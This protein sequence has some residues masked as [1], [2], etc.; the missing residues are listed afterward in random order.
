M[1]DLDHFKKVNDQ[2]GHHIGDQVLQH[3]AD[4]LKDRVRQHDVVAR[5]GGEEFVLLLPNNNAEQGRKVAEQLRET[6]AST[7]IAIGQDVKLAISASFGVAQYCV[8]D[9]EWSAVLHRADNALYA[10]KKQGRNCVVVMAS[11]NQS[12][13]TGPATA[14]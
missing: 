4:I 1:C 3:F 9:R 10:A 7:Q 8:G 2:Y 11:A 13:G 12:L 14:N 6:T 5:F